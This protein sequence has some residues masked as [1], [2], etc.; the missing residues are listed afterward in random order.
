M[1]ASEE[2]VFGH[3]KDVL[4]YGPICLL[5]TC[6][7][8]AMIAAMN[9]TDLRHARRNCIALLAVPAPDFQTSGDAREFAPDI[10]STKYSDV[11]LTISRRQHRAVVQLQ[12]PGRA[13]S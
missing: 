12:P 2:L 8:A 4:G 5:V 1:N 3:H 10:I 6:S 7:I 13:G 11:R 9:T